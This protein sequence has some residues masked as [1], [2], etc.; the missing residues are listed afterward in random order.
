MNR[1]LE[2]LDELARLESREETPG[3]ALT[4]PTKAPFVSFDSAP[5]GLFRHEGMPDGGAPN[6]RRAWSDRLCAWLS[7]T[8]ARR[9][10][11]GLGHWEPA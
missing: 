1:Y 6:S 3:E 11:A 5:S 4:E 10:P 2:T 9:A 7:E 8:I